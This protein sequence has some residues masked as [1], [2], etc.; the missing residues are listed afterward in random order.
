MTLEGLA[1]FKELDVAFAKANQALAECHVETVRLDAEMRELLAR[2]GEALLGLARHYLP[3]ISRK[4][5]ESTFEGIRGDLLAILA[6]REARR[7]E[8]KSKLD[9]GN[10]EIRRR[11]T[12][13]DAVTER[14]NEK[15]VLR[16]QLEAKVA[17]ILKLNADFQERSKL[18][19]QA[20]EKLHRD[21]RRV[22]EL[23]RESAEKL[24]QYDHSRLFRYL[25]DRGY[26]TS[27]YKP[28]GWVRSLDRW[29]ADLIDYPIARQGYEFLKKTPEL[30]AA[31]V[32]RRRDQFSEL[33]KQVEAI[34]KAEADRIGL[35]TVL[36]DGDALGLE[37][38]RL[39]QEVGQFQKDAQGI[40]QGLADLE[41]VQD[42]FYRQA[43]ERFRSFL[44][45]TKFALLEKRARQ[46]PEPEDD[47]IVAD[48]ATLDSQIQE[49]GPS[50]SD[51]ARRRKAADLMKEGL[52]RVIGRYRQANYDSDRSYFEELDTTREI[53]RFEDGQIDAN[54]LWR[55]IQSAQKFRP[56]WVQETASNGVQIATS[57]AGRVILGAIVDIAG[58]AMRDAAYRGVQ[59]RSN[60]TSWTFPS[61][62]SD[63]SPTIPTF[64]SPGSYQSPAPSA[65]DFPS[66]SSE[67]GF[68]SGEGF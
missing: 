21:E 3:E 42:E 5:I 27:D 23:A 59:R 31:E 28:S 43:F 39:V 15:V 58:A 47:A 22:D 12:E 41:Q 29:V 16:E 66:S 52:D 10:V 24:P 65:P 36:A 45:E 4:A 61:S 26:G 8:L 44:G 9:Q 33:M 40:Q 35:T 51:L 68:T 25:H 67:G 63:W 1:V 57:P 38:D 50:K 20:E 55:S 37:R 53:A 30:V 17:E 13:I 19:L 49:I 32:S 34:E 6:R 54:E 18:A 7:N 56:S 60:G 14:L 2:R 46:T 64:P 11:N 48:L 62:S